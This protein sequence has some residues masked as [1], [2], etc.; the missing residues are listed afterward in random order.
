M[1][2]DD[3][4]TRCEGCQ[5]A[6]DEL[7]IR[8]AV[9][10]YANA[11]D[12]FDWDALAAVFT[13]DAVARYHQHAPIVGNVAI[14]EFL[15]ERVGPSTWHQHFISITDFHR[16]G[17]NAKTTS[18]FIAHSINPTRPGMIRLTLGSYFDV[19][20]RTAEGWRISQRDQVTGQREVR[21]LGDPNG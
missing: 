7:A 18:A 3:Q 5:D 13:V 20:V 2:T 17:D 15:R 6:T 19:L 14:A 11:I 21:V 1:P 9:L 16:D 8:A 10:R 4:H 12:A